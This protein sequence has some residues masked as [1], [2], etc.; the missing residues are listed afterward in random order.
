[1]SGFWR[2][3]FHGFC[4]SLLVFGIVL[5]GGAFAAT[6]GPIHVLLV[7]LGPDEPIIFQP[8]LRFSLALLGAVSIG[9]TVSFFTTI[10]VATDL[11]QAG[12][13]LWRG[14]VIAALTWYV[15][16]NLLSVATGF[17]LNIIPNTV[18]LAQ[19]LI[20]IRGSGVLKPAG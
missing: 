10:R 16:D 17:A 8:A 3:W 9:W 15:I 6:S 20:G 13:P 2:N 11:G 4:L 18:L 12:R 19:F 5:A 1:M 7:L 14:M